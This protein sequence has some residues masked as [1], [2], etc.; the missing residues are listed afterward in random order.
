M[1]L[2]VLLASTLVFVNFAPVLGQSAVVVSQENRRPAPLHPERD[3]SVPAI[4]GIV[5]AGTKWVR[6]WQQTGISADGIV[7]L[8]DGSILAAQGEFSQIVKIDAS[9]NNSVFLTDT[10]GVGALSFDRKGNLYAVQR[11][12]QSVV[13]LAPQRRTLAD[14][15]NGKPLGDLGNPNDLVADGKGGAYFTLG[16]MIDGHFALGQVYYASSTGEI[17]RLS[18]GLQTNGVILARNDKTLYVTNRT[19]V[20]AFDVLRGGAVANQ[21]EFGQL[22]GGG[23]GDGMT[24]D[25]KGHLYISTGPG[26][27][28]IGADGKY[29]GLIPTPRDVISVCFGGLDKK[30]LYVVGEGSK[31]ASGQETPGRSRT[32]YRLS[33]LVSGYKRRAK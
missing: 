33:M 2:R 8:Q 29:L 17:K 14:S 15:F 27:Q 32:I 4:P 19:S 21:R 1:N 22:Q 16:E 10:H 9:G 30:S 3:V 18:Q 24:I 6:V 5:A 25:S 31:D 12:P 26:I 13:I 7:P 20:V 11:S 23:I 28:I